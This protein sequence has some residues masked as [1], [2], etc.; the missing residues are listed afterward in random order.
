[1]TL[2]AV[3]NQQ[4]RG[5][6]VVR[7]VRLIV[8]ALL[9]LLLTAVPKPG[10]GSERLAP[11]WRTP[12]HKLAAMAWQPRN[13]A[14]PKM[15]PDKRVLFGAANGVHLLKAATG[16]AVWHHKSAE[17]VAG[18][19]LVLNGRVYFVTSAGRVSAVHL[20]SGKAVWRKPVE[21]GAV[22]HASL[23][24]DGKRLFVQADPGVVS[25][26][27]TTDGKVLW[28][29]SR[30]V[31]RDFL[32][33]GHGA[34]LVHRGVVFAGLSSGKLV[35][36]SGRDGGV[37]WEVSLAVAGAGPYVDV[38]NT[39]VVGSIRGV[40]VLFVTG[41]G[42]GLHALTVKNG[43]RLWRYPQAGLGQPVLGAGRLYSVAAVGALHIVDATTGKRVLA[44]KLAAKPS[45]QL[46]LAG[47]W[48]LVP[49][50]S[51]MHVVDRATGHTVSH[52]VD[53]HG[54]GAAPL[55]VGNDVWA[56]ANNGSAWRL[57]LR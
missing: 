45:G 36:L 29:D 27:R 37:V 47:R 46:A 21:L 48:L 30:T 50:A 2:M 22:V 24:T 43:S 3:H 54:F 56:V 4:R 10:Q 26:L 41:H 19:P 7:P 23:A 16:A 34:P 1:M 8:P 33:E 25:A 20:A 5:R 13:L 53:E 11:V 14:V 12:L 35:A 57:A 32:V 28:R 6:R 51:G 38:D 15:L 17:P 18:Q 52:I 49:T 9:A 42:S 55:V 31:S 40:E 39:P 44:R